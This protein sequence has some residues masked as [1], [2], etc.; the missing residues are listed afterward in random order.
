MEGFCHSC[1]R[2]ERI[3][4][5]KYKR[6]GCRNTSGGEPGS[7]YHIIRLLTHRLGYLVLACDEH[8]RVDLLL[9]TLMAVRLEVEP[10]A[11]HLG[12]QER[13]QEGLHVS[14]NHLA[15]CLAMIVLEKRRFS[16]STTK[17]SA[18]TQHPRHHDEVAA[19]LATGHVRQ[20]RRGD[21]RPERNRF[22][23]V[24]EPR[25]W[26][27]WRLFFKIKLGSDLKFDNF[28]NPSGTGQLSNSTARS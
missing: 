4:I 20:A 13:R 17:S 6:R 16:A 2:I 26:R 21:A 27:I 10:D 14:P 12:D 9:Q 1:C 28:Q 8:V 19:T 3:N 18:L 23:R 11:L 15:R 25:R 24:G 7:T 22:S 5:N